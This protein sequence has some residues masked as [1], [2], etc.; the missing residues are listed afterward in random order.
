MTA[1]KID[2]LGL[3][4]TNPLAQITL[5]GLVS[6]FVVTLGIFVFLLT[7][8]TKKTRAVNSSG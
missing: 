7:Q 5:I 6:V 2:I 8:K 1:L 3:L 4:N